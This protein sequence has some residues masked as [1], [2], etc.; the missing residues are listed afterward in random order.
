MKT[1]TSKTLAETVPIAAF[2][3]L[4]KTLEILDSRGRVLVS[5]RLSDLRDAQA[6][7]EAEA[8]GEPKTYRVLQA[9]GEELQSGPAGDLVFD[10]RIEVG[11]KVK[12]QVEVG[13]A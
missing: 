4:G 12:L 10:G 9:D 1:T 8:T 7:A 11:C 13:V 5:Y 3:K 6:T 2:W